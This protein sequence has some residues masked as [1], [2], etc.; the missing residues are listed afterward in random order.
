MMIH[1]E[2]EPGIDWVTILNENTEL[3]LQNLNHLV[4]KKMSL[5]PREKSLFFGR[6][7]Q[8]SEPTI[9]HHF[10]QD[11]ILYPDLEAGIFL[12]RKLVLDLWKLM[13]SVSP[14]K[15]NE[16]LPYPLMTK[17]TVDPAY[18]FAKFLSKEMDVVLEDVPEACTKK[19]SG[20]VSFSRNDY[21]CV[22][23]TDTSAMKEILANTLVAVKTCT[24]FHEDRVKAVLETW[25]PLVTNLMLVR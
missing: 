11:K 21:S 16:N 19:G 12:S 7:L 23:K 17:F 14:E 5:K 4:H 15:P 1:L 18:E 2:A 6:G 22:T 9:V 3:D 25:A 20:C 10:S 13:S 24:R 8:D